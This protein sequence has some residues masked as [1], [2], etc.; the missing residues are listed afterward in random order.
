MSTRR[1]LFA[2]AFAFAWGAVRLLPAFSATDDSP[3]WWNP[4][5]KYRQILRVEFPKQ[6]SDLP[7][8]FLES[9][10]LLGERA[11]TGRAVITVEGD[12]APSD[13]EIVV[14][15]AGG[16]LVPARAY[17]S[18]WAKNV[19]VLFK[20]EPKS[21]DYFLYYGNPAAKLSPM[22]WRRSAYPLHMV[23][24]AVADADA[25]QTPAAAAQALL[26]ATKVRGRSGT[27][28]VQ[29]S[30]NPFGLPAGSSYITL[31]SG[32]L[33]APSTGEYEFAIDLGGT[34]HLLIDQTLVLTAS[35]TGIENSWRKKAS[36]RLEEGVHNFTLL[37]GEE[38]GRQGIF[39]GWRPP[40]QT[41]ITPISGTAF[42]R[43]NYIPAEVV[44]FQERG[45]PTRPFFTV[46]RGAVAFKVD[47]GKAMV[48][49]HLVN[50][51]RGE[52]LSYRWTLSDGQVLTGP[53][54]DCFVEAGGECTVILEAFKDGR[55]IGTHAETLSLRAIRYVDAD[56]SF[57]VLACPTIVYD[58]ELPKLTFEL[59]NRSD[60]TLPLRWERIVGEM[61]PVSGR[62]DL[63]PKAREPTDVQ[64]PALR[65]EDKETEVTFHVS[66]AGVKLGEA[67]IRIIRPSAELGRLVYRHGELL[68]GKGRRIII[69]I[70]PENEEDHRRWA[71]LRWVAR[72]LKPAPRRILL[73]GDP[74]RNSREIDRAGSELVNL[75]GENYAD[76]LAQHFAAKGRAFTFV[77]ASEDAVVP[78]IADIPAFAAALAKHAP[79]LV[80]ISP[81]SRDALQGVG[82]KLFARTADLFI[83]IARSQD[84][85]PD[86]V[87]VSPPPL[88]GEPN[89][90]QELADAMGIIARR[91]RVPFVNLHTL[92]T[93]DKNWGSAYKDEIGDDV[94]YLYP[95]ARAQRSIA[96]A[97]LKALP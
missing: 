67:S 26:K 14:T 1:R 88:A 93:A 70:E 22:T 76:F 11:L 91:H 30:S 84:R 2:L 50:L 83:D 4:N 82:R 73:F 34:A 32:I 46:R 57:E 64:L 36:F 18:T 66:L 81:G 56:A 90:S 9:S 51:T 25:I 79:D 7:I 95:N 61:P 28:S 42:A 6:G 89:R 47:G 52:G 53:S 27:Y 63:P 39:V 16:N 31:Y 3:P 40:D 77:E 48:P 43:G 54:P 29:N 8:S 60:N 65:G 62:I 71:L 19:T 24:V 69:T 68:D 72:K 45:K 15:D 49:L 96:D 87:L 37:H 38:A 21:A 20:A 86:V 92:L 55:S 80:I 94:Y 58:D 35:G 23:T 97:V 12:H 59:I 85:A 78:C 5:W 41:R 17:A 44:G 75:E 33:Y 13:Q 74:M 10:D